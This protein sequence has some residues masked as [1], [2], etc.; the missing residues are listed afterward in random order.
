LDRGGINKTESVELT[1][2]FLAEVA[3]GKE[4][5]GIFI[6]SVLNSVPFREDREHIACLCAALCRPH[7]KVYACASSAGESGWRQV[8]GKA[9]MNEGNA[10]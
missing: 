7:T 1:R 3:A 10:R 5:T 2:A 9:F 8:T 4:W 6:A